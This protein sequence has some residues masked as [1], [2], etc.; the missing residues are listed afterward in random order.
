[1]GAKVVRGVSG[2]HKAEY[3]IADAASRLGRLVL[4]AALL[5]VVFA[6]AGCHRAKAAQ[7][8]KNFLVLQT[9]L[10][11]PYQELVNGALTGS[12]IR[13][14]DCAFRKI[15]VDY[16]ITLAPRQ[17]NRDMTRKGQADG[18]FLSRI[19]SE[20]AIYAEPTSP[21]AL[22]KWV[23]VSLHNVSDQQSRIPHPDQ[24]VTLGVVLGS[25]EAEWI[26]D[27][28]YQDVV[29]APSLHS[30]VSLLQMGRVD[31]ALIDQQA[32]ARIRD[33]MKI[34]ADQFTERFAHYMP[35]VMYFARDYTASHPDTVKKLN[36]ALTECGPAA[37]R[38]DHH[39]QQRIIRDEVGRIRQ[40]MRAP[41]L[42]SALHNLG[43]KADPS[44]GD[45]PDRETIARLDRE[46]QEA[47]ANGTASRLAADILQN[48]VSTYLQRA[49][50]NRDIKF[51]EAFIFNRDGLVVGMSSPTSNYDQS[52]ESKFSIFKDP[53]PDAVQIADI[54]YDPSTSKFLSQITLPLTDPETGEVV[55]ALTV[56]LDVTAALDAEDY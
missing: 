17:R 49:Y 25:N 14:L 36:R 39:E 43:H 8:G 40:L 33:D 13:L 16:G 38:L 6:V 20:M 30:L 9:N 21:L 27:Q 18:F 23:W 55:A 54:Y 53:S 26:I 7:G 44:V 3:G 37:V 29:H 34:A 5:S 56:G 42:I 50:R 31:F 46:W 19:S 52:G 1:M 51:A 12:T 24:K 15:D 2:C 28:G 11:P 4:F 22:E 10:Q 48:E 45:A 35:L 32:F 41:A 47:S